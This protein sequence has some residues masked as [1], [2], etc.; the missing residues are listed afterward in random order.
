MLTSCPPIIL[1]GCDAAKKKY[2]KIVYS[3]RAKIIMK[4]LQSVKIPTKTNKRNIL[5]KV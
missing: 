5:R 2:L 4:Y 1:D 3:K